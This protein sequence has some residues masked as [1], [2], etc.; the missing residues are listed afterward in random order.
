MAWSRED[1]EELK[2]LVHWDKRR[3]KQQRHQER[4]ASACDGKDKF[5]THSQ[6]EATIRWRLKK[7]CHA[8]RCSVCNQWHVGGMRAGRERRVGFKTAKRSNEE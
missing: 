3:K 1:M 2:E 7:L 6:A 5:T 8:Y 4:A